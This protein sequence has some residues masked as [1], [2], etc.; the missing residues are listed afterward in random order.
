MKKIGIITLFGYINYGNRLQNYAIQEVLKKYGFIVTTLVVRNSIKP[1]VKIVVMY[2]K[3]LTNNSDSKRYLKFRKFTK[4]Y[5]PIKI[6]FAKKLKIKNKISTEYD[7]FVV[8]SDQVW[9][10]HIR[11]RERDNFFLRFAKKEQRICISPSFGVESIPQNCRQDYIKGLNGFNFLCCRE[12]AG[13]DIIRD[14]TGKEAP[15]LID[16]TLALDVKEWEKIFK[17]P[18]RYR[19]NPYMLCAF[20]GEVSEKKKNKIADIAHESGI[21]VLD[22]FNDSDY[23]PDELL[24]V[25]FHAKLVC[26]DSFHF[27]AFSINFNIPFIVFRREG[28][29]LE[30]S[31]FSRIDTL[32]E[33]FHLKGRIFE[34]VSREKSYLVCDFS[35]A[36]KTLIKERKKFYNYIETIL[37]SGCE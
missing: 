26:T 31:M 22:I 28:E 20:L 35:E 30:E 4:K 24:Y 37:K 6:I 12:S 8:G 19:E 18:K 23:G 13:A 1:F 27:C 36:N 14:L 5:I 25:L 15:V 34:N 11:L 21:E 32:L 2:I 3:A 29:I 33:K 9:N 16:P 10:P 7:Y 17:V